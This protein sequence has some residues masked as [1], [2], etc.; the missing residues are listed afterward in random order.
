MSTRKEPKYK[1]DRKLGVNLWGRPKSP[2]NKRETRPGE[3][4]QKNRKP[5]NYA[6]QLTAKQKLKKYYGYVTE[7]QFKKYYTQAS[8]G[9]GDTGQILIQLL[10]RRLDSVLYRMKF[11]PTIFA[12]RQFISHGHVRVNEKK[13]NIPSYR[14]KD[15]DQIS[16]VEKFKQIPSVIL[17]VQ[18]KD[19][20]VPEYLT[21]DY[22]KMKG[23][24]VKSPTLKDVPYPVEMEPNLVVEFY[25][26]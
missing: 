3:H 6:L 5:S 4:G 13:I 20:E 2:Y 8:A 18:S 14:V 19:R 10:E 25:S 17:A 11:A 15:G 21:V 12:S 23:I 9:K 7:R 16:L 26:R 1:I 22:I 24:F